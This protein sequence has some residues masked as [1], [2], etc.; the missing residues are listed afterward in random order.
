MM[1]ATS[2]YYSFSNQDYRKPDIIP[3]STKD[4]PGAALLQGITGIVRYVQNSAFL[5]LLHV[6]S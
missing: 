2:I 6:D 1:I 4:H 5:V 3:E